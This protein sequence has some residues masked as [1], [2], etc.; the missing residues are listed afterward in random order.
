MNVSDCHYSTSTVMEQHPVCSSI[1]KRNDVGDCEKSPSSSIMFTISKICNGV[2][3]NTIMQNLSRNSTCYGIYET[4]NKSLCT[5]ELWNIC[6]VYNSPADGHC[7]LHSVVSSLKHQLV[8]N[9]DIDTN[10]VISYEISQHPERYLGF[11]KNN[12]RSVLFDGFRLY[13]KHKQY[14]TVFGDHIPLILANVLN[15]SLI[16]IN[17]SSDGLFKVETVQ[18]NNECIRLFLHKRAD[19]YNAIIPTSLESL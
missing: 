10:Y 4:V 16:I 1:S 17:E 8:P 14:D 6:Q 15:I 9:V 12:D 18:T 3:Q 7:L 5:N 11:I 2:T 19:H 13:A